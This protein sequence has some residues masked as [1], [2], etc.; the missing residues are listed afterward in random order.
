MVSSDFLIVGRFPVGIRF[1]YMYRT[2][3][4]L[5][6]G[7][8]SKGSMTSNLIWKTYSAGVV[9]YGDLRDKVKQR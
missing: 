9:F 2:R 7:L 5:K 3:Q 4:Q 1:P 6:L 8:R